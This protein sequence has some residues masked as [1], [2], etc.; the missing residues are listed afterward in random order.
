MREGR[1]REGSGEDNEGRRR[2]VRERTAEAAREFEEGRARA[3]LMC[4]FAKVS[5]ATLLQRSKTLHVIVWLSLEAESSYV[6]FARDRLP[7]AC[8]QP[9]CQL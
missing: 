4:G 3:A 6:L 2:S 1:G 5:P 9:L 8:N 7:A